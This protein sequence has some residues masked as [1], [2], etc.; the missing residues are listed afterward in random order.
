MTARN[1]TITA[2]LW[3]SIIIANSIV[4]GSKTMFMILIVAA[5]MNILLPKEA[6]KT[7]TCAK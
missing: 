1:K 6:A 5:T 7:K 3:A 4:T 2:I